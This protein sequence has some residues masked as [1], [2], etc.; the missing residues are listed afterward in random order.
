[1]LRREPEVPAGVRS[2][3]F[4]SDACQFPYAIRIGIYAA[5]HIASLG[6]IVVRTRITF[7]WTAHYLRYSPAC[8]GVPLSF[9]VLYENFWRTTLAWRLSS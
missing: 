3:A 2:P 4:S 9:F 6:W 8:P 7:V 1:V 5:R